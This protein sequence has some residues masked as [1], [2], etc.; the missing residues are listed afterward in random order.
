MMVD[1]LADADTTDLCLYLG[2]VTHEPC[3]Q[4]TFGLIRASY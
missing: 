2:L 3:N 1:V 4:Y